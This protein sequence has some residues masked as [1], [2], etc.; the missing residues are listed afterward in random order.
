MSSINSARKLQI[1]YSSKK[2]KKIKNLKVG[3]K[4]GPEPPFIHTTHVTLQD[5]VIKALYDFMVSALSKFGGH[6][7]CGTGNVTAL[8]CHLISQDHQIKGSWD[9]I[10]RIPSWQVI[11]P[12]SLV[13]ISILEVEI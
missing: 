8:V 1:L 13:A 9:F 6:R 2:N 4:S 11:I 3:K 10:R 5:H 12:P 7:H